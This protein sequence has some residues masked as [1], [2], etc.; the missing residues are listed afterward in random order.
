MRS[1]NGIH[2]PSPPKDSPGLCSGLQ[3]AFEF[4]AWAASRRDAPSWHE[5]AS[6]WNVSRATA[7]RY[8]RAYVDFV[9]RQQMMVGAGTCTS[10]RGPVRAGALS[11]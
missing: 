4:L 6:R 7:C 9:E 5:I 11:S 3:F 10:R 2:F 1:A 8:R